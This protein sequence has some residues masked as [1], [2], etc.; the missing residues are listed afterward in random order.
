MKM[1]QSGK[2]NPDLEVPTD[3]TTVAYVKFGSNDKRVNQY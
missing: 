3:E 1:V 2:I